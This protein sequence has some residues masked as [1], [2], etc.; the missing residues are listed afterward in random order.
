MSIDFKKYIND[1]RNEAEL[2]ELFGDLLFFRFGDETQT[3]VEKDF[4][5]GLVLTREGEASLQKRNL[6]NRIFRAWYQ[7]NWLNTD[8]SD[9]FAGSTPRQELAAKYKDIEKG[10]AMLSVVMEEYIRSPLTGGDGNPHIEAIPKI[11][12]KEAL[13]KHGGAFMY[14]LSELETHKEGVVAP[15][16]DPQF[17]EFANMLRKIKA[18]AESL[19][20]YAL[21]DMPDGLIYWRLFIENA[22]S[23]I[24]SSLYPNDTDKQ[25]FSKLCNTFS[26]IIFGHA[27]FQKDGK[28]DYIIFDHLFGN[29][30]YA[31]SEYD[32]TLISY[33]DVLDATSEDKV[34]ELEAG[35][36]MINHS[37]ITFYLLGYLFDEK[38]LFPADRY[39]NAVEIVWQDKMTF[40]QN[41]GT[42]CFLF[43][44]DKEILEPPKDISADMR[45]AYKRYKIQHTA[46]NIYNIW[47]NPSTAFRFHD[48]V[49]KIM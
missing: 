48:W 2:C 27:G 12:S 46:G 4:R 41:L 32:T 38:F 22:V 42:S 6:I 20:S 9:D 16:Y 19:P 10:E 18:Y 21:A 26:A 44:K 5:E 15:N 33:K 11:F 25:G 45:E 13:E 30:W 36:E 47:F 8:V 7:T 1:P 23:G 37:R 28:Y 39:F 40:M 49:L 43:N 24:L 14:G 35:N 31:L 34:G 29:L 3:G 17:R